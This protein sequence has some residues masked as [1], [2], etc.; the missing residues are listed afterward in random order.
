MTNKGF[1]LV[2]LLVVVVI[3][4]VISISSVVGF[5]YLGDVMRAREVTAFMADVIKQEQLKILRG[6]YE[7]VMIHFMQDYIVVEAKPPGSSLN[8]GLGPPCDSDRGH[9][10]VYGN[11][12]NLVEKN[13]EGGIVKITRVLAGGKS[14]RSF[15]D[16]DDIGWGFQLQDGDGL[17]REI[18]FA[19]FNL[20]RENLTNPLYVS[21]NAGYSVGI[22]APYGKK[23]FYDSGGEALD[24]SVSA[25][26][27]ITDEN[28]KFEDKLILN[29]S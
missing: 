8:L 16:L 1:S 19:H 21:E 17:S 22:E 13:G 2:E 15:K 26:L 5:G 9:E 10:I 23:T 18:R 20:M 14:C 3:I 4:T 27:T 28:G 6:D 11:D 29:N 25:E 12:A 24:V 7:S